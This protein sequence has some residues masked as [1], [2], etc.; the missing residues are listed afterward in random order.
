MILLTTHQVQ[1]LV[2]LR[3]ALEDALARARAASK[4]LRGP[5]IVALD[6]SVERA[7]TLVAITRGVPVPTNAKLDDLISRLVQDFGQDWKPT[8]LPD[9]KHLRRARNASQHEGLEPDREQVPLWA[10]ATETFV[11]S[12]ILAQF[13]VVIQQVVLSDAIRD[14]KLREHLRL[15][16]EARS[17]Y[18]YQSSVFHSAEAFREALQRWKRLRYTSRNH[19][20]PTHGEML[21]R[22]SFEY[23][24]V[25]LEDMQNLL[26][27]AAFAPDA[28][29]AE[30]F[31]STI[32][33]RGNV[34]NAEDAE[35]A[36]AFSF[37]WI[38]EYERAAES[39]V[40]NRRHRADVAARLVGSKEGTAYIE[41]CLGVE[42]LFS[43]VQAK[44]R[45]GDVPNED[46]YPMWSQTVREILP[47]HKGSI[48][49]T[50]GDDGTVTVS[51]LR[52][53]ASDFSAQVEVL[54]DAL[55][56]ANSLVEDKLRHA[57]AKVES[58]E[59]K[60]AAFAKS[61]SAIKEAF[62]SWVTEVAWSHDRFR[63][64]RAEIRLTVAD[65]VSGLTF[66]DRPT[67]RFQGDRRGLSDLILDHDSVEQC[68]ATGA[69]NQ[70]VIAPAPNPQDLLLIL[71]SVD[72][73]VRKQLNLDQRRRDENMSLI[74]S[75]K[76][77]I[78][79]ILAGYEE[80]VGKVGL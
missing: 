41:S 17:A 59:Q 63:E 10:S 30:W 24:K 5:S 80:Y 3:L 11:S 29:E 62:P 43:T 44:F 8:V 57:A 68:Y 12:I 26:D 70:L 75:A 6:A 13:N 46:R 7:S 37:E 21:D 52:A 32:D 61:V 14:P 31:M 76:Q 78:A 19:H 51:K 2:S 18:E 66:G 23:L 38:V 55:K 69:K 65:S 42:L 22:E 64:D 72:G 25:L 49:W 33:E 39:W 56:Q 34:L 35:R 15:G 40:P 54:N 58:F 16:E 45:I 20:A 53:E 47:A 9:I 50:V 73:L 28:A 4:Y 36:L 71:K 74:V 79:S 48:Y 67:S 60:K 1:Q 27:T 77:S